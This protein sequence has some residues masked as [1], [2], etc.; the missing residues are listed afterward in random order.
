MLEIISSSL[1]DAKNSIKGGA[2]RIELISALSEGGLT[3]SDGLIRSVLE[4]PIEVAVMLRPFSK[5]F[6]YGQDE[7]LV[8]TRDLLRMEAIGVKRIVV[9]ALTPQGEVDVEFLKR[10]F[11]ATNMRATFHRAIDQ[12]HNIFKS[13]EKINKIHNFTH[14]LSSGGPGT[15]RQNIEVLKKMMEGP[16]QVVVGSGVDFGNMEYLIKEFSGKNY[17]LHFGRAVR[18]G[19]IQNNVSEDL[20]RKAR[21]IINNKEK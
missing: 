9:G 7:L 3:P 17:D 21:E 6:C 18:G 15:A 1:L 11:S 8:M 19:D 14:V 2:H 10:L 5:S 13:L 12:S 20:V 4:L 16:L